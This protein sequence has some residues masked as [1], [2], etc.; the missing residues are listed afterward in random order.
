[1]LRTA[2]LLGIL[3]FSL[4]AQASE[5]AENN[6]PD[7]LPVARGSSGAFEA[8][9]PLIAAN[10]KFES[11]DF[12]GA[13]QNYSAVFL[14]DP[15]N[16]DVLFGLAESALAIGKGE[17]ANKAFM[18]LAKYNLSGKQAS[19]QFCGLVLAEIAAGTSQNP[20]ARLNQALKLAPDNFKLWNALGQELD[21][22]KR[23]A[24][25]WD[26]YQ[27]ATKH[28]F[29]QSGLHNNLGMSFLAQRKY[30]GAQSHFEYAVKLAPENLQFR[31]NYRF[32]LLMAGDY[33]NALKDVNDNEAGALLSDAGYIAMQR[34]D[35]VLARV[36]LEKAV[37]VSP[38]YN[39]RAAKNLD[40]LEAR[41]N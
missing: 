34:E 14:H 11:G 1:M 21:S 39:Q 35:Y 15:E 24:E 27:S 37:E 8:L 31:N 2:L 38:S 4:T 22:Q 12:E 32:A 30:H 9:S 40:V 6:I 3:G 41:H 33:R 29:S 25:S 17:I 16:V 20:E 5:I 19:A 13:Y 23:W 36:L 18:R 10:A 26:A 7:I 28:G